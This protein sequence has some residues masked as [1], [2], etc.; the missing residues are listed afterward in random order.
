MEA[1]N[2]EWSARRNSVYGERLAVHFLGEAGASERTKAARN[3]VAFHRFA[4]IGTNA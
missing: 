3:S 2:T 4:M 1:R